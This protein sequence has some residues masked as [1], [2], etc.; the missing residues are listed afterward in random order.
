MIVLSGTTFGG[1]RVRCCDCN[2]QHTHDD[3]DDALV[4]Y[5]RHKCAAVG[6]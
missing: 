2:Y 3:V 1:H 6:R 5:R 4:D